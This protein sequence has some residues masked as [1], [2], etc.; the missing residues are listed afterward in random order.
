MAVR[1]RKCGE[2]P[3]NV[4]GFVRQVNEHRKLVR[5][6]A[7]LLGKKQADVQV[8]QKVLQQVLEMAYQAPATRGKKR[9][10][11]GKLTWNLPR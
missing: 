1:F 3:K 9:D 7:E 4:Q 10:E 5:V 8:K 2:L 6:A 11:R